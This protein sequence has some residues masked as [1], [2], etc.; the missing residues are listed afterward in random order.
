MVGLIL[1]A[2]LLYPVTL[3]AQ[4]PAA[5][6]P[7]STPPKVTSDTLKKSIS[8]EEHEFIGQA[9]LTLLYHA[10][11]VRGRTIWGG[12]VPFEEVWVTG[13]HSATSLECDRDFVINGKTIAAGKYALFTIPGKEK[14]QVIIN[15]KWDQHLADE[16]DPAE[17]IVRM[18]VIPEIL[19]S[20]QERLKYTIVPRSE[21]RGS[22]LIRWEKI[23][24]T[25]PIEIR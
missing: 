23:R 15:K 1:S 8:K 19:A 12:L 20:H 2:G 25:V 18:E 11:S 21:K 14:W 5:H 17:D 13:A 16:Y 3:V 4:S 7:Q 10:P 6:H 24:I 9:H 22:I